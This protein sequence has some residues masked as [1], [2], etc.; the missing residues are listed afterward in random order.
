MS[1]R[2]VRGA[3]VADSA[4]V[5]GEVTLGADASV[6]FGSVVR[7][8]VAQIRIGERTNIQDNCT[9]HCDDDIDNVIGNRVTLAHGVIAHGVSIGDGSLIGI[10]ATL[11]AGSKIGRN[12]LVAAG[13]V[14][15][16]NLV[17]E[18]GMCV[19]GV[20]GRVVRETTAREK[21]YLAMV[22]DRYLRLAKLHHEHPEDPRVRAWE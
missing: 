14:V 13:A 3:Y 16:P 22:P 10:G 6:W 4:R 7:G 20:P 9:I 1:M 2:L 15:P 8:D 12:C 17:V 5:I 21:A 11:L 18:D 19:M